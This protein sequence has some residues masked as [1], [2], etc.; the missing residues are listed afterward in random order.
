MPRELLPR[1]V[2][3]FGWQTELHRLFL[4]CAPSPTCLAGI[5]SAI[6]QAT[7]SIGRIE[8]VEVAAFPGPRLRHFQKQA[9]IKAELKRRGSRV[10]VELKFR[11]E[12][13]QSEGGSGVRTGHSSTGVSRSQRP[14][15][16]APR[17]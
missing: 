3:L 5:R 16:P 15:S 6:I 8:P 17:P 4:R 2:Q 12:K 7:I 1:G 11:A 9:P 10:Q 14:I 13:P